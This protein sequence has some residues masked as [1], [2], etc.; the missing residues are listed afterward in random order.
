MRE[1]RPRPNVPRTT[2]EHVAQ[3]TAFVVL[4]L[5]LAYIARVWG[6]LPERV[7]VHFGP[8]GR[9]DAWGGRSSMLLLPLVGTTLYVV[10]TALERFPH[11]YNYPVRVTDQNAATLYLLGRKLVLGI[12]LI[13]VSS[14]AYL[15]CASVHV[16]RG[17]AAGLSPWFLPALLVPLFAF[18][19]SGMLRMFRTR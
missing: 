4:A 12:K 19:G 15:S 2:L 7:P 10:S 3:A 11:I 6:S 17:E 5:W 8:S 13:L 1:S 16:A 18:T 9:V 14:F